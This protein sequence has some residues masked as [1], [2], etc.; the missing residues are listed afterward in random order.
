M[1]AVFVLHRADGAP[2]STAFRRGAFGQNDPFARNREIAWEGP[3]AMATGRVSF[4][5][6][7]DVA[8][9]P[10]IETIVVMEGSLT[11][12]A[13]G[14]APLVLGPQEGAVI[15]KG[16]ALRFRAR[17]RSLFVFCAA[18][19]RRPT[20]TGLVPLRAQADFKP[21]A[22]L[23]AEVLLGPAPECRSDNVFTDDDAQYKAGT[24]DSTPY[25]RIVRP[26]RVNEFMH[27]LAGGV[28]FAAPDGSVLSLGAGDALFVPQGASVGWESSERVAK[29]Y[30]TQTVEAV[31]S[32]TF[33]KLNE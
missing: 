3:D 22:T 2:A 33:R 25:H 19:C 24:W 11:L 23:P 12:E 14:M 5:G 20:K 17:A 6:E 18:A 10:H 29:F 8:S 30:V 32:S 27:L 1:T 21:S 31:I 26:H 16:T 4:I 13:A 7:L 15:G 28:R 9:F